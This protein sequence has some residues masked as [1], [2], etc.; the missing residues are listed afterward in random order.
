MIT[1]QSHQKSPCQQIVPARFELLAA[2]ALLLILFGQEALGSLRLSLTADEP[3]HIA[4]H[5][6]D[7]DVAGL[8]EETLVLEY[9]SGETWG[10][11]ACGDYDRHPD[12]NWLSVPLCH[13]SPFALSALPIPIGGIAASA[14]KLALLGVWGI[15]VL[16]HGFPL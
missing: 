10:D 6:S 1:F 2:V 16:T 8:D 13:L 7:G 12:E 5:Y 4:I 14:G 3:I 15:L 9:R 11:A